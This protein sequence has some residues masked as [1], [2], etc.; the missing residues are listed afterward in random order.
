MTVSS[1]SQP[2]HAGH[3][4]PLQIR[5][6]DISGTLIIRKKIYR[7][8]IIKDQTRSLG[9][10]LQKRDYQ[11]LEDSIGKG[12]LR[13]LLRFISV[14]IVFLFTLFVWYLSHFPSSSSYSPMLFGS[15]SAVHSYLSPI[16]LSLSFSLF[17]FS[18][19]YISLIFLVL[20]LT[21]FYVIF[22]P[23]CSSS[24]KQ[25]LRRVSIKCRYVVCLSLSW[26]GRVQTRCCLPSQP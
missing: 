25:P 18:F 15:P 19:F 22:F 7:T 8:R 3:L 21:L 2:I 14:C 26:S 5:L 12:K 16:A 17:S 24:L 10:R 13:H 1:I 20:L 11:R 6:L 9:K 4:V 23:F